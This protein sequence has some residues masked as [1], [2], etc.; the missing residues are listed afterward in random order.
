MVPTAIAGTIPN[1]RSG[2]VVLKD[3]LVV[4]VAAVAA[5]FGGVALAFIL[6][7]QLS[8]QLFGVLLLGVAIQSA[9]R[10]LKK[11]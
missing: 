1:L 10:G 9:V 11:K 8:A 6:P 3:G 5:S 4:G 2:L 7:D